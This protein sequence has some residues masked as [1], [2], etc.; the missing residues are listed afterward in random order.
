MP[1]FTRERNDL[2]DRVGR[3][4]FT[5]YLHTE[6]PTEAAPHRGRVTT[7]GGTYETGATVAVADISMAANATIIVTVELNFGASIAVI[8]RVPYYTLYRGSDEV[9]YGTLPTGD[10]IGLLDTF[11]IRANTIRCSIT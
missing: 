11:K 1:Y 7:G 4:D 5:V 2:M 9:G 6:M 8:G 10:P 3:A